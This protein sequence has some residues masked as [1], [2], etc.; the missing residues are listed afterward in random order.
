MTI[1]VHVHVLT[2]YKSRFIRLKFKFGLDKYQNVYNCSALIRSQ[3]GDG[4]VPMRSKIE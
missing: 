2:E 4:K 3:C 1:P